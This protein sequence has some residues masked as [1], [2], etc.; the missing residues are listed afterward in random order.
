MEAALVLNLLGTDASIG[1]SVCFA[2]GFATSWLRRSDGAA[3]RQHE[4]RIAGLVMGH[5]T[6]RPVRAAEGGGGGEAD[7]EKRWLVHAGAGSDNDE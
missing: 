1:A 2:T 3:A 4:K 6:T 5:G 7:S